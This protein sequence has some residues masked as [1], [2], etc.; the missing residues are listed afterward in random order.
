MSLPHDYAHTHV[1]GES[2]FVDDRPIM[3]NELFVDVFFSTRAHALIKRVDFTEVLKQPG[4]VAVFTGHDFAHNLWGTIFKDQPILATDKVQYA[5]EGIALIVATS[6]EA[7]QRAKHKTII[8]YTD[9]AAVMSIG[10]ARKLESFIIPARTI[11]RGNVDE[12]MKKAPHTLEGDIVIQGHDH[13]YLESQV[14]I[15]YPLEDG[16]IEIHSSSQHPTETQ[17]V[18]AHALGLP[19]NDVV[20]QVK[21]MGGGFGGKES[22]A[23]PFAAMAALCAVKL[24]RPVRICLTK[25][26]DMIM[27]GKRNPFE[28]EYKVGFD[29]QGRILAMDVKLFSDAG[30]YADLSTSIMERAM[31]HSDN[32]YFIPHMRVVGQ[33]CKTNH[34]SHTAFRG[35]GGP[36]G[37]ATAEK[38]IE[39]IAHYLKKDP[40]DVRKIN[41]YSDVDGRNTTHYGQLVENNVLDRLVNELE[42]RSDY[43]NRRKEIT[44]FNKE[45]KDFVRGM[46]LTTVKFGISFTTRFLNQGNALVIIHN[47]GTL[48]IATGATEMG[49]GVNARIAEMVT[50]EFGLPRNSAR[51]MPTRTDKNANTSPTAASSGTDING[52]AALLAAR[53]I[54]KRLSELALKLLDIPKDKWASKTAGLGTQ[55][56]VMLD[57]PNLDENDPNAGAEWESGVAK[58]FEMEFK[59][60]WVFHPKHLDKKIEFK[61]LILEAYLNRVSLSDYAFYKIPGI[62]FNK[63]TGQGDAFLYFTQGAACSEVSLNRDTGEVKVLRTDI[64]MDLGRPV[65]HDLDVGQVTGAFIQG[66]GWVTTENL[67]YNDQ[68]LL[69]SHAPSTYKIPNV[70]DTPRVF[71]VELLENDEN[72][73]NVRGTKAVGEPPLLLALS[74]WTAVTNALSHL[75]HYQVDYPKIRIPATSENVLREIMP[76]RFKEWER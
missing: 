33:V 9:L 64:L 51:V 69:L 76:E 3:K 45:N 10:E 49:Q 1:C 37:V 48:Q 11:E 24:K 65:N 46:S 4:V 74:A 18:V 63:M 21:R 42:K 41:L 68:G 50:T 70:Q 7:A 44:K 54:K 60:G 34:H 52:A 26:D 67:F 27:T 16:Q 38:I 12:E 36:K 23:A 5:G 75:P 14:S 56:E 31:L 43:R 40:I 25:D 2:E 58:Y 39:A 28:N 59:D 29:D 47:D 8:E 6:L 71:N 72:Y 73:A 30:A 57:T 53:K 19:D 62:E 66:L 32:S 22:Q 13:F 35:F 17:H 55:P 20:C 15:A 61:Y